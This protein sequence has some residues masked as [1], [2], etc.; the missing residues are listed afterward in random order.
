MSLTTS[1]TSHP[2]TAAIRETATQLRGFFFPL[3]MEAKIVLALLTVVAIWG[4]AIL[5]F[6]VPALVWPMAIIV[7]GIVL[8]LV[9]L[10]WGM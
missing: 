4:F 3:S 5:T 9:L 7:P 1:A 10:T 6:G 2:I 8:G